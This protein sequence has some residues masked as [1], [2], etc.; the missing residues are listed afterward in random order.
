MDLTIIMPAYNE[1]EN[2]VD[3][4]S[5][6][7]VFAINNFFK[8]IVVNDGS[9]DNSREIVNQFVEKD[10]LELINHKI[11][12]GYGSAIKTGINPINRNLLL[13]TVAP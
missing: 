4:L 13:N 10:I 2:L 8:I 7:K 9:K 1:G 6:L 12:L 3:V 11:N 5:E